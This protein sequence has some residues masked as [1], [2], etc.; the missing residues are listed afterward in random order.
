M[1]KFIKETILYWRAVSAV[2]KA[3]RYHRLTGQ[4]IVVLQKGNRFI[5]KSKR[6]L[7]L[8]VKQGVLKTDIQT[9]EE[10]AFYIAG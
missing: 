10:Q 7:K 9:L 3:N 2:K 8:L 4:K 1:K 6:A 5:V